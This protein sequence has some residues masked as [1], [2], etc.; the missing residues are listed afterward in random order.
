MP[1]LLMPDDTLILVVCSHDLLD[2]KRRLPS[3]VPPAVLRILE[4]LFRSEVWGKTE[5]HRPKS[6]LRPPD[7]GIL[8]VRNYAACA[9]YR[10]PIEYEAFTERSRVLLENDNKRRRGAAAICLVTRNR[11]LL[12]QHTMKTLPT[13]RS[14]A[15]AARR[16]I[17]LTAAAS[18]GVPFVCRACRQQSTASTASASAAPTAPAPSGLATLSSRRLISVSGPDA[19]KYLQGVITANILAGQPGPGGGAGGLYAAFLTAQGRVLHDVFVYH[20]TANLASTATDPSSSFLIEVDAA[21][22]ERLQRHIRRYKLRARFDVRLLD[23]EEATVSHAWF[24]SEPVHPPLSSSGE[25]I[26][27]LKDTRAPSLGMRILSRGLL[28]QESLPDPVPEQTY[29]L[30][31][32]LHGIAEGQAEIARESAL[33]LESNLDLAGAIDFRKGCYVGQELT[34]RTKHRGV[35]RKRI[36]PC[37]LYPSS[38]DTPPP[39]KLEYRPPSEG[40]ID[41]STVPAETSIGRVGR[42]GRSAGKW[43]RGVGN[44]GL[45]LCRLEIMTDVVLP[46]EGAAGAYQ[47]GDEFVVDAGEGGGGGGQ[48]KIKAFVPGWMR[49]GLAV[50]V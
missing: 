46:G 40:E 44:V 47:E 9:L 13:R 39:A 37:M 16:T 4:L 27:T 34:I 2:W 30:H 36:L 12:R 6:A 42:K 32:Y 18:R 7:I 50:G 41:A 14:L 11:S 21:E 29:H 23:A 49:D 28:P 20:D 26:I 3:P 24:A 35:V 45:A 48:V 31:R 33:P 8:K 25:D 43:L 5:A 19:A 15:L 17:P 10:A 38:Q 22:A 1:H